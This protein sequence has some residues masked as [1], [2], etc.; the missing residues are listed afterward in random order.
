MRM[1]RPFKLK[2]HVQRSKYILTILQ[3]VLQ[4]TSYSL[5]D[6]ARKPLIRFL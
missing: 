3:N 6:N 1:W 2:T 4:Q 5:P